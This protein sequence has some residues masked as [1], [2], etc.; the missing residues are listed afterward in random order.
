MGTGWW[1]AGSGGGLWAVELYLSWVVAVVD[2]A[3]IVV[4]VVGVNLPVFV[5]HKAYLASLLLI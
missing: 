5:S 1:A 4:A 3:L 2:I